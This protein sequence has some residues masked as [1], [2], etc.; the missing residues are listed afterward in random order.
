MCCLYMKMCFFPNSVFPRDIQKKLYL[1]EIM[2]L[3]KLNLTFSQSE[4]NTGIQ[5]V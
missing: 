5:P 2:K 1:T 4:E 3:V